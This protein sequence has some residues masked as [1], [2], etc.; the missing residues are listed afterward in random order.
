MKQLDL[1]GSDV[2]V[3]GSGPNGLAAALVAAQA[4]L[5]VTVLERASVPGGSCRSEPLTLPGFSHDVCAA[6]FPLA[7]ASPFFRTLP[8]E[9]HGLAWIRSPA[10]LAHPF[11][12]GSA[13]ILRPSL[14]RTL[15]DLGEAGERYRDLVE[16][17]LVSPDALFSDVLAPP[18]LP[19]RPLAFARLGAWALRSAGSAGRRLFTTSRGR[20]LFA[21][22][23][24]HSMLRLEDPLSAAAPLLLSLAAHAV[25]WPLPR[26]GAGALAG[27]L[28]AHLRSLGGRILTSVEVDS[29][30]QLPPARAIL[31]DVTARQF[32]RLAGP[33]LT[34]GFRRM[35]AAY[36]YGP[37]AFKLD[38]AL[39]RPIPW[40]APD[41]RE[42]ATVH[43]GGSAEEIADSERR[44]WSGEPSE[45]PFVLVCQ[46]SLF[47]ESRAPEGA[48]TAWAYSHVPNGYAGDVAASIERQ[49]ERF[50][51]G[52]RATVIARSVLRPRDLEAH[53]PNLVGGD[54][55][56]GVF[57][58]AQ[59]FRRPTFRHYRTSIGNVFLCSASTP[60]GPGVHGMCGYHAARAALR[61]IRRP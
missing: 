52:F 29:L 42:A 57:D 39:E 6:V 46:P 56:G 23:G 41:C 32:L 53:N 60:P 25:G 12:D 48:H 19:E 51:P 43:L 44:A 1:P 7:A 16:S 8:L 49:I 50:A 13:A 5:S 61:A 31:C 55:S 26:G 33:W 20:A 17:L 27:A 38:W 4:G 14:E 30:D 22:L 21:G 3:I 54:I 47:D 10:C 36:R 40:S 24:A 35:L 11:D 18:R 15:E 45:R 59:A 34:G 2:F 28:V 9:R 58:L 37:A